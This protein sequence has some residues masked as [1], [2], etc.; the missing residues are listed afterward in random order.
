MQSHLRRPLTGASL[1]LFTTIATAT[2]VVLDT[3]QKAAAGVVTAFWTSDN[4]PRAMNGVIDTIRHETH[5]TLRMVDA[6]TTPEALMS[7]PGGVTIACG[8]SGDLLVRMADEQPRVLRVRWR[9]CVED[10]FGFGQLRTLIG[11][12]A[13][14]LPADTFRPQN[15]LA[16]RFGNDAN[17]FLEKERFEDPEQIRDVTWAFNVVL[18]GDISMTRD[19]DCCAWIGTSSFVMNGYRDER[20]L[21]EFPPGTPVQSHSFKQTAGGLHVVRTTNTANGVD[22]DDTRLE[23]GTITFDTVTPPPSGAWTEAWRYMDYH[24]GRIIDFNTFTEQKLLNGRIEVNWS[25]LTPPGCID[26]LYAFRTHTPIVT[27]LNTGSFLS[28]KLGVNGS[29]LANFYSAANT[30]PSLPT[31]VNGMLLNMRVRDVGTFNY[32][33]QSWFDVAF[34]VA[35]CQP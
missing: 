31:P 11:P 14:T 2:A 8:I 23:R 33:V 12:M 3:E 17:E 9:D 20:S 6:V 4:A 34:N 10:I 1:L 30:P 5:R 25:H 26:G 27:D 16:I 28:G 22:E 21:L 32:D 15:V 13:I 7:T 35:R 19:F 29:V 18:R 24:V